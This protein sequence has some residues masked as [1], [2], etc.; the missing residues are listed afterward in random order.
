MKEK[1][2]IIDG[3]NLLHSSYHV[4]EKLPWKMKQGGIFFFLR[5]L[6]SLLKKGDY[7]KL[8]VV[9]DGGGTNFRKKLF[10]HYKAQR[11]EM[12]TELWEQMIEVKE[13]LKKTGI[14]YLQLINHEADDLIASFIAQKKNNSEANFTIFTRDKD[15]LQLLNENINI[16]KYIGGKSVLYTEQD[17]GREYNFNPDNYVDYLSLLGD[18]IDNIEGIK[19]IGPV[20]AKK[21]IQQFKTVENIYQKIDNLPENTKKMLENKEKMVYLNKKIINLEKNISLPVEENEVCNFCWEKWKNNSE[22]RKFCLDNKFKSI[23]KLLG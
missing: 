19:G 7:Q 16:L 6:I 15:L 12:P 17:F 2:L 23:L 21:L 13:L 22:L 3:N 5:V 10:P 18:N 8:L 14:N 11:E 4:A 9:F 1:W 20:N